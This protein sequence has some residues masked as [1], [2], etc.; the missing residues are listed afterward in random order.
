MPPAAAAGAGAPV[1]SGPGSASGASG[2]AAAGGDGSASK[3]KR[4]RGCG[5]QTA[6]GGLVLDVSGVKRPRVSGG[7]EE[8]A[9]SSSFLQQASCP[10][11]LSFSAAATLSCFR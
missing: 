5:N 1:V 11:I 9:D 6:H 7:R 2:A 3:R 10:N 4:G 8:C